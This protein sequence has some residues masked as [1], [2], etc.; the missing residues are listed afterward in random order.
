MAETATKPHP[1]A[2]TEASRQLVGMPAV[3]LGSVVD[4]TSNLSN[5]VLKSLEAGERAAIDALGKFVITIEEALPQEVAAST[6]VAKKITESG[7]ELT[8]RLVHTQH[9][10]LRNVIDSAARSLRS[11]NGAKA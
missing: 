7:L 3:H 8:D 1:V 10:F 2:K 9:D 11:P 4:R 6:D 5:E